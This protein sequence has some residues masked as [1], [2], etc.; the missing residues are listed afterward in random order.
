MWPVAEG[1]WQIR[2]PLPWALNSVNAFLFRQ[3]SGYLLLDTGLKT[4]E[5]LASLDAAIESLN[6][7]WL[8]ITRILISHMHPDHIG[9][10]AELRRRSGA[11][12]Q[13]HPDEAHMVKPREPGYKFFEFAEPHMQEHGVPQVDI[14]AMKAE[15][16]N[17]SDSMERLVPDESIEGGDTIEFV[18]GTLKT[19]MAPGHSPALMCF[20]CPEQHILFSTDAILERTTPNIGVH[21]FYQGN[22]LGEYLNSLRILELLDVDKV[23]PSHGRPF[24]GHR[25]WIAGVRKH[26]RKRCGQVLDVVKDRALPAYEIAG[27]IW[28]ENRS[29]GTRRFAMAE[30]L[31]HLE[32]M[33]HEGRVEQQSQNGVTLWKAIDTAA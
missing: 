16:G 20:H 21:W 13:M 29:A 31:S 27:A 22:P 14:D 15:A 8:A 12:I 3:S 33:S 24:E 26:H 18:G 4:D 32:Y 5:S 17:V 23:V 10:A 7:D 2:L 25:E 1:A 6:L 28:G 30:G 11:P 19:I 9:A